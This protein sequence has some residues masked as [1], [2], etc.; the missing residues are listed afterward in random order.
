MSRAFSVIVQ[1]FASSSKRRIENIAELFAEDAT[2]CSMKSGN[3]YVQGKTKISN[4]FVTTKPRLATVSKRLLI[5]APNIL[6]DSTNAVTFSIDMHRAD[7]SPG[8]G[9]VSKNTI[10]LYRCDKRSITNVWGMTDFDSLSTKTNLSLE[11]F[12]ASNA[13][14][15]VVSIIRNDIDVD[16]LC[17]SSQSAHVHFHNYD[18]IDVWG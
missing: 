7:T 13:W 1:V 3:V 16:S 14:K 5:D 15:V 12:V 11:A 4:S 17:F 18:T 9:D 8:L 6:S 2:I 10:L